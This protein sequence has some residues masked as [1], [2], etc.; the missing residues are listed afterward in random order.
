MVF[1][2]SVFLYVLFPLAVCGY[3]VWN[4]LTYRNMLLLGVS[5]LF[6][7]WGEPIFVVNMV[8]ASLVAYVGGLLIDR[9]RIQGRPRD[10]QTAF[11]IT[12][13][14]LIGNLSVFK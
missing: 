5:L 6:Y 4:D 8:L 9:F 14:L 2:E 10:C 1:S 12:T 11:V 7:A 13:I 3:F